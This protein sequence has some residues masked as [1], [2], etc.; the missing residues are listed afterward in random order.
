[1]AGVISDDIQNPVNRFHVHVCSLSPI[2]RLAKFNFDQG[3]EPR[4]EKKR[5]TDFLPP[6]YST[7]HLSRENLNDFP[8]FFFIL[9]DFFYLYPV[10]LYK[11]T[12][13]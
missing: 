11:G 12:K 5:S 13:Q 7:V 10:K 1:M 8:S 2:V 9:I 3:T 4:D 6:F